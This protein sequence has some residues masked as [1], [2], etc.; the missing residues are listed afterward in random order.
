MWH[1][2]CEHLFPL[3]DWKQLLYLLFL[4]KSSVYLIPRGEDLE[5]TKMLF[6][7]YVNELRKTLVHILLGLLVIYIT[8]P[9]PIVCDCTLEHQDS[10]LAE[11]RVCTVLVPFLLG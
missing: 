3:L 10:L 2:F 7:C 9:P 4:D 11:L 8:W 6:L 5:T 1:R